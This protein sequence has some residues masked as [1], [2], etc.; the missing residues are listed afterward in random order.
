MKTKIVL[1]I[2]CVGLLIGCGSKFIPNPDLKPVD[3]SYT[4]HEPFEKT[5]ES[6]VETVSEMGYGIQVVEKASGLLTT[7]KLIVS[8]S[9]IEIKEYVQCPILEIQ[10][11]YNPDTGKVVDTGKPKCARTYHKLVVRHNFYLKS[12]GDSTK[13]KITS[14]FWGTYTDI[15][16]TGSYPYMRTNYIDRTEEVMSTGKFETELYK[17]VLEKL[18]K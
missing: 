8:L 16:V 6:V 17:R 15:V 2:L 13:V 5:W 10:Q 4:I 3:S 12:V 1:T 14:H 11:D 9:R 18:E 7:D